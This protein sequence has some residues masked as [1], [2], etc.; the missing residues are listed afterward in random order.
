MSLSTTVDLLQTYYAKFDLAT[1]SNI[2]EF[3]KN[4]EFEEK[5]SQFLIKIIWLKN[6]MFSIEKKNLL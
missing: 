3:K 1:F 6:Y 2:F 4:C 5:T